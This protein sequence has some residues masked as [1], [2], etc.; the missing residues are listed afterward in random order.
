VR[1]WGGSD[2][3]GALEELGGMIGEGV[4]EEETSTKME[5]IREEWKESDRSHWSSSCS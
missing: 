3:L 4:G 2:V 1:Q 5:S